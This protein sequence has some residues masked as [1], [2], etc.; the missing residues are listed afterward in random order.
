MNEFFHEGE[1][2]LQKLMSIRQSSDTLSSMINNSFPEIAKNFLLNLKFCVISLSIN[3]DDL[4]SSVIY[5]VKSFIT[6]IDDKTICIDLKNKSYIPPD[7]FE[8]KDFSIGFL[9]LD[10]EKTMRMRINGTASIK[11]NQLTLVAKEIYSNCPKYIR[12]RVPSLRLKEKVTSNLI[13]YNTFNDE[14]KNVISNTD[15]FFFSSLHKDK[16]ADISHRGGEKGFIRIVSSDEIEFDDKPG[17]NFFN[18]LGNIHTNSLV[19]ILLIDFT[20]NNTYL[21]FANAT[22][23]KILLKE[24]YILRIT[25]KC[26]NILKNTNSFLMNYHSKLN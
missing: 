18:T 6:I 23:K 25:L 21:L 13:N 19:N 15:T 9:G 12:R 8:V 3:E 1:R 4:F 24:K 11:N 20:D 26:L 10:F 2:H 16:G 17:N 7:Y 5:G 22:F 14:L